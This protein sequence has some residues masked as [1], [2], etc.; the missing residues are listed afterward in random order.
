ME[1]S[2]MVIVHPFGVPLDSQRP[3][4]TFTPS[5]FDE[6]VVGSSFNHQ[7]RCQHVHALMVEG[8]HLGLFAPV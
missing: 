8:V 5:R 7:T 3:P 1:E 2:V 6:T 4:V